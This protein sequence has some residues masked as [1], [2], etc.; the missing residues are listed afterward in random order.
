MLVNEIMIDITADQFPS[1]IDYTNGVYVGEE[2]E[3]Y[4]RLEDTEPQ[5]NYNIEN[6]TRLLED[7]KAIIK[8]IG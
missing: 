5:K 2:S 3:F 8:Y 7:Y 1:L 6:D 4:R